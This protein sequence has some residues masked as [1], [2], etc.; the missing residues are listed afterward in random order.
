MPKKVHA[1][2]ILVKTQEEANAILYDLKHGMDFDE[3]AKARSL[4]PSGKKGGDLGWFGKNQMVK[5]FETA[6]FNLKKDELSKPVKTQF[7]YH[8]IKVVETE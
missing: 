8:I 6:A 5:E 7:G 4:C 2:H 3:V 1:K